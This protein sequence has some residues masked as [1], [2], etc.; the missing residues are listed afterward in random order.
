MVAVAPVP[1]VKAGDSTEVGGGSV[2]RYGPFAKAADGG[3]VVA[4]I[5]DGGVAHVMRVTHDVGLGHYPGL[6]EVAVGDAP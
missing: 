5:R 1:L 2:A 4:P 3:G 6:L